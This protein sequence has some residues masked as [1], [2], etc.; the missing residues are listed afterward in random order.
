MKH[1]RIVPAFALLLLIGC[2]T[3]ASYKLYVKGQYPLMADRLAA[4]S[5][6]DAQ[7][8]PLADGLDAAAKDP[9]TYEK[10]SDAWQAA[11]PNFRANVSG[12]SNL[13]AY[14]RRKW[15]EAADL[16]DENNAD[17][18]SRRAIFFLPP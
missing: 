16:A 6:T 12:D 18:A 14:S 13:P 3:S 8:Q 1:L 15:L 4:Y 10:A 2:G 5:S 17:E 9:V 7:A 11:A